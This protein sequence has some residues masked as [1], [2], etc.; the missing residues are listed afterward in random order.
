M[1]I[2]VE[3]K[4]TLGMMNRPLYIPLVALFRCYLRSPLIQIR[5]R[6]NRAPKKKKKEFLD[7]AN[8]ISQSKSY[9]NNFYRNSYTTDI[10]NIEVYK[11]KRSRISII[12]D[13]ESE[14][15]NET[16]TL[17]SSSSSLSC[18]PVKAGNY[19]ARK[20][21]HKPCGIMEETGNSIV[22][23]RKDRNEPLLGYRLSVV[24]RIH[25]TGGARA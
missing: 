19:V 4:I 13:D 7:I 20:T 6:L 9:R 10:F 21:L 11:I 1:A 17:M 8:D 22:Y 2:G 12:R 15:R 18:I 16:E 14:Q 25:E 24:M 23:F 5:S 3:M